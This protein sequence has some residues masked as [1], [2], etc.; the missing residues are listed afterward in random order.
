MKIDRYNFFLDEMIMLR[1]ANLLL[2]LE[3]K[4]ANPGIWTTE[5]LGVPP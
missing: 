2:E 1:N 4:G 3:A 5:L